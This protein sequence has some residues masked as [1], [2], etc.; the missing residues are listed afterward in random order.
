MIDDALKTARIACYNA[1]SCNDAKKRE[2]WGR[3]FVKAMRLALTRD[4]KMFRRFYRKRTQLEVKPIKQ[5]LREQN[6]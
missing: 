1:L 4:G 6:R 5:I 3:R 2:Y